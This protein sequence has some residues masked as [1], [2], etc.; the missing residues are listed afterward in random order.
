M[1]G[2]LAVSTGWFYEPVG[3]SLMLINHWHVVLSVTFDYYWKTVWQ[4]NKSSIN[5]K[6]TIVYSC[7]FNSDFTCKQWKYK[8]AIG[9]NQYCHIA[10]N[11]A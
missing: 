3:M 11:Y 5:E 9:I 1:G 6:L 10:Y 7:E 8:N 4:I 2:R